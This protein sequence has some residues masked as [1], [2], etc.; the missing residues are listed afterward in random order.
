MPIGLV[1]SLSERGE[2]TLAIHVILKDGFAPIPGLIPLFMT[3]LFECFEDSRL[4]KP[5]CECEV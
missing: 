5:G 4:G 2:E 3:P 1:A